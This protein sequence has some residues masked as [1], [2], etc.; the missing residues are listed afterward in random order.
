MEWPMI[1][2]KGEGEGGGG[3]RRRA[4]E[5]EEQEGEGEGEEKACPC[6]AVVGSRYIFLLTEQQKYCD[7]CEKL[8]LD[9]QTYRQTQKMH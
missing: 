8:H 1:C 3:G 2:N 9:R 5:G 7:A 6:Q 4:G